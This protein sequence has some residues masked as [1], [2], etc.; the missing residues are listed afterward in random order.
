MTL[1]EETAEAEN[2]TL[3]FKEAD[4]RS[5]TLCE[6][7]MTIE[8]KDVLNL[9]EAAPRLRSL[10]MRW[11]RQA[12]K[13]EMPPNSFT[14]SNLG[15]DEQLKIER[16]LGVKMTRTA[17]GKVRGDFPD[18]LREP[19]AW[20]ALGQ[21]VTSADGATGST[22][23]FLQ[24]LKWKLPGSGNAVD[25]LSATPEVM[26]YLADASSRADWERLFTCVWT[27]TRH[28]EGEFKT[29]SQL[30]S[31]WFNDS[32]ILRSGP[33]RRQL[34]QIIAALAEMPPDNEREVLASFFIEDNPYTSNVTVFA[35]FTFTTVE[36]AYFDFPLRMF[37]EGLVCQFPA[38]TALAI[39]R[40]RWHGKSKTI[41]TSEN[42]APLVTFVQDRVPVLYTEG[43]PNLAVLKVMTDLAEAGLIAEHWGDADL[44]GLKI[45]ALVEGN[46]P[47]SRIV[48][49]E[50]LAD[51]KGQ[52][53]IPLTASQSARIDRF[54]TLHPDF[55]Y[56]DSV[57]LIRER[58]CWYEQ[59]GF[60]R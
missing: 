11:V 55:T 12:A 3:E 37:E 34:V 18:W 6:K 46:M 56:A 51:P 30:G 28:L 43:N 4:P 49:R 54:L 48:A 13:G 36:G 26:R 31:D 39:D 40:I 29:L 50:V 58:G 32:K 20:R 57:R 60:K 44:D 15:Y 22:E 38:E 16:V 47:G 10:V 14:L 17:G 24:R 2:V 21:A 59:E 25:D 42:A 23:D 41:V 27:M 35:P 7:N 52:S 19:T 33:L 1:R 53:G 5:T 9:L 8:P 45:A